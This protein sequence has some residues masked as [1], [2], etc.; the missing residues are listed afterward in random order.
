MF[1]FFGLYINDFVI[2]MEQP[3]FTCFKLFPLPGKVLVKR[4][5]ER[6]EPLFPFREIFFGQNTMITHLGIS[7]TKNNLF[8]QPCR[9][10]M[11]WNCQ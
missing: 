1:A 7:L 9:G 6:I 10:C 5:H 8:M 2:Q 4:M 11:T 3:F